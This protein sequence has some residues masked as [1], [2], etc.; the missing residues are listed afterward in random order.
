MWVEVGQ[1]QPVLKAK[2]GIPEAR[3]E[4]GLSFQKEVVE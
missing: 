1:R 3:R 4:S 2:S